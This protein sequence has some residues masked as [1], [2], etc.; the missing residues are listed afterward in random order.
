ML[1]ERAGVGVSELLDVLAQQVAH[2]MGDSSQYVM[3]QLEKEQE[4]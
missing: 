1:E 2:V 4:D 3:V